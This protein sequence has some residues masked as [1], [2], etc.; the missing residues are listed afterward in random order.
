MQFG[1][2]EMDKVQESS[3]NIGYVMWKGF[4]LIGMY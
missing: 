3:G 2:Y 1:K 4:M